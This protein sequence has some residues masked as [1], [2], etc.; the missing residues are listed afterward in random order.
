MYVCVLMY[1]YVCVLMYMYVCVC[2][3]DVCIMYM[4]YMHNYDQPPLVI[5]D[6]TF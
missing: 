3:Y 6:E 4:S 5:E 2:V 1:V